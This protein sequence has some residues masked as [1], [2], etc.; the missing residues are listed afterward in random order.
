MF[1]YSMN[2]LIELYIIHHEHK[3][4]TYK[5]YNV[6]NL[7]CLNFILGYDILSTE[8]DVLT[9]GHPYIQTLYSF[10]EPFPRQYRQHAILSKTDALSA[11]L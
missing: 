8:F 5:Q 1:H 4:A 11:V 7:K 2:A 10:T 3:Y 6:S 9:I